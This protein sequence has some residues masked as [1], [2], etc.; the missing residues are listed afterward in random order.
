[1]KIGYCAGASGAGAKDPSKMEA[2]M[3]RNDFF[4]LGIAAAWRRR[5]S[6]DDEVAGLPGEELVR[7]DEDFL[8]THYNI[9]EAYV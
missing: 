3:M 2:Q 6:C 7:D 5:R 4:L 1:M 8:C 9:Q